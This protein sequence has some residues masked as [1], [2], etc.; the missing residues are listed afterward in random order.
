MLRAAVSIDSLYK[1]N[2]SAIAA[3]AVTRAVTT[4]KYQMHLFYCNVT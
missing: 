1:E 3:L 2:T 4:V